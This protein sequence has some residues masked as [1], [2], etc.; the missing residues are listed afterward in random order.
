MD[1]NNKVKTGDYQN[2]IIN[3]VIEI[4]QGSSMKI[5]YDRHNDL[6]KLDR[7]EPAIFAKPTNYGFIP[8]TLDDD[9]DEL[10]T[11]LITHEPLPTGVVVE[12]KILGVMHFIDSGELDHKIICRVNDDRHNGDTLNTLEDIPK[13]LIEQLQHHFTHYKDLKSP[14][15]TQVKGFGDIEQA[16]EVISECITR[17]N[18]EKGN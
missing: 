5:E 8:Q 7:A 18:N 17:W 16:K 4:P 1:Y 9:G 12:A 15:Q 3:T 13:L 10:D 6:F 11:L 14:N 2:G